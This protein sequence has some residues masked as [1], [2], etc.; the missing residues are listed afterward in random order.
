MK[1][2]ME[3]SRISGREPEPK[4]TFGRLAATKRGTENAEVLRAGAV[5]SQN[6]V[7]LPSWFPVDKASAVL[8]LKG[9]LFALTADE[10]GIAY[11]AHLDQLTAA[12]SAKS[13]RWCAVPLGPAVAPATPLEQASQLMDRHAST[14]VPV[15][16]GGVVLGVLS[17]HAAALALA[18]ARHG[19]DGAAAE[20]LAA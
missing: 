15:V 19:S 3:N 16:M 8:R 18:A 20:R 13:L 5:A 4:D 11:V 6:F 9:K 17:R 7:S 1:S 2:A 14:C 10:R 12:P